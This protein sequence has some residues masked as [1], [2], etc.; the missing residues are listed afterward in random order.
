MTQKYV[1]TKKSVY[2]ISVD[3]AS[4]KHETAC[5]ALEKVQEREHKAYEELKDA[6]EIERQHNLD[7]YRPHGCL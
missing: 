4:F 7:I 1:E 6:I 5:I 2:T 3:K